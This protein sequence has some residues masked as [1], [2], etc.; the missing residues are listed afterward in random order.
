[1]TKRYV[2]YHGWDCDLPTQYIF[3]TVQKIT[4]IME[5]EDHIEEALDEY[6]NTK[7]LLHRRVIWD[8]DDFETVYR[9]KWEVVHDFDFF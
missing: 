5:V 2:I 9:R 1:M 7:S 6:Y 4:T 3:G 8:D